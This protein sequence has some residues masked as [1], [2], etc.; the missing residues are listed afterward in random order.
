MPRKRD[1]APVALDAA[2]PCPD[3]VLDGSAVWLANRIEDDEWFLLDTR[4]PDSEPRRLDFRYRLPDG[5]LLT[6]LANAAALDTVKRFAV[7]I[8]HGP[9]AISDNLQ[10]GVH[11]TLV[12]SLMHIVGWMRLNAIRAFADLTRRDIDQL[13][14]ETPYGVAHLLQAPERLRAILLRLAAA[15]EFGSVLASRREIDR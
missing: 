13:A 3:A 7:L 5:S 4:R 9:H 11:V 2:P 14:E 8:R 1:V 15:G 6:D 12:N 10:P